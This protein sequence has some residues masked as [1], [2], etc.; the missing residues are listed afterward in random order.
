MAIMK[1]L[2]EESNGIV[3]NGIMIYSINQQPYHLVENSP[4]PFNASISLFII[5]IGIAT[6][7]HGSSS[8]LLW[9]GL[10]HLLL[11]FVL[12]QRDII[13]EATYHGLHSNPVVGGLTMGFNLFIASE[14]ALFASV[15]WA[16]FHSALSPTPSIGCIWPPIG[17]QAIQP[18]GLPLLG[19]LILLNS[20]VTVTVAHYAIL[21]TNRARTLTYLLY[22]ILLGL[23]FTTIQVFE[24]NYAPFTMSDGIFGSL[25]YFGTGLHGLHIVVGTTMLCVSYALIRSYIASDQVHLGFKASILYWHFVDILW[26]FI[27]LAIYIWP[28]G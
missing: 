2:V 20:G 9:I 10:L 12:W 15:F 18:Y 24:Y 4:H 21:G 16:Y 23:I 26:V 28:L 14:V 13:I 27:Y 5:A 22:T 6:L 17:I 19:S 8:M 7:L 25:F 11:V 1:A 3:N